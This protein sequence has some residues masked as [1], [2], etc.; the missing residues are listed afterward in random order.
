MNR[1]IRISLIGASMVILG[2]ML[3]WF[4]MAL[5]VRATNFRQKMRKTSDDPTLVEEQDIDLEHMQKSA[6]ASI[7]VAMALLNTSFISSPAHSYDQQISAW[8][9]SHRNQQMANRLDT[10][11]RDREKK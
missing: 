4:L 10:T 2:L 8:Q 9:M 6:A 7:A 1:V 3:L 11:Y 5:L